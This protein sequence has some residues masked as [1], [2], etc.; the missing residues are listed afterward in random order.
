M[1]AGQACFTPVSMKISGAGKLGVN[2]N[3]LSTS[4]LDKFD[5]YFRL[6]EEF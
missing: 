4:T 1:P 5:M 6:N 3:I 2:L